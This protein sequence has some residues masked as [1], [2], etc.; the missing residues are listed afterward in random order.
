VAVAA[1][2]L[3]GQGDQRVAGMRGA[4]RC[5]AARSY[6]DGVADDICASSPEVAELYTPAPVPKRLGFD[7]AAQPRR[8]VVVAKPIV[9]RFLLVKIPLMG[10]DLNG[11][12]VPSFKC[13]G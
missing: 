7:V 4:L 1:G 6:P 12:D 5:G 3:L 11:S 9:R 2:Q 8:S 10:S 13:V